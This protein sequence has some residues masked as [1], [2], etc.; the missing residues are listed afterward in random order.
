MAERIA[1]ETL[2][3]TATITSLREGTRTLP[4]IACIMPL[5]IPSFKLYLVALGVIAEIFYPLSSL[6]GVCVADFTPLFYKPMRMRGE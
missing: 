6:G 1:S 3:P 4:R 2:Y 5:L